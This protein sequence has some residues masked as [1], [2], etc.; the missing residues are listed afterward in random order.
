[1]HRDGYCLFSQDPLLRWGTSAVV[2][3][4]EIDGLRTV[5]SGFLPTSQQSGPRAEIYAGLVAVQMYTRFVSGENVHAR[6][7]METFGSVFG[8]RL[9]ASTL[10]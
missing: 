3:L 6:R 10:R 2:E 8:R 9:T 1:M 7:S 4:D 5:F